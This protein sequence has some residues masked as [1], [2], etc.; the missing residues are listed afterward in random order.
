MTIE[1]AT[2]PN[3]PQPRLL[4]RVRIAIRARHYSR[5]TEKA[6]VFWVRRYLGFHGMRHPN[7]MGSAEVAAFL[8]ALATRWRVSAS[9]Q[10]QAFSALLFLY[11]EVLGREVSGLEKVVR[12]KQPVRVPLVLSREEVAGVLA[13]LQGTIL[14]MAALLYGS[15]L[16]L[17]ECA[18]L[19]VKDVDLD[20]GELT[21][22]AGK[23]EKDRVTMLPAGLREPL[24]QHLARVQRLHLRDVADGVGVELPDSLARKYPAAAREWAWRWVF[25]AS[26]T[27]VDRHTGEVRRHHLHETVLQRAFRAAVRAAGICKPASCHTLRHSFATHLLETGYDL[28]TIQELLGHVD[29]NTTMIYAHVLNRGGR[30]V[31]SPLDGFVLAT[32]APSDNRGRGLPIPG[33]MRRPPVQSRYPAPP[34]ALGFP[35]SK[36]PGR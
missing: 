36:P 27:Y 13:Q 15:G 34:N 20:R 35:S 2:P 21:V 30:G 6:Y 17:L 26:R 29:V 33:S 8:A 22:R 31:R 5:R 28:R 12:A 24:R 18:R 19:R 10:N 7:E 23:G 3:A 9:T 1:T 14:L 11:R 16:R 32:D 25:P 4:D